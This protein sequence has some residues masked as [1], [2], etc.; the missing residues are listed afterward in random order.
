MIPASA[1]VLLEFIRKTETGH[2]GAQAYET[3]FA[4]KQ[5]ILPK[6]L[7]KMT[8]L[9]VQRGQKDRWGRR[10]K[11]SASGAYQFMY[12]TLGGLIEEL[13]LDVNQKFTPE[14]QDRLGYH[15]LKRR[16]YERWA[17]GTLGDEAFAKYLAMEWAS[18]PVLRKGKGAHRTVNAGQSY[19]AGDGLNKALIS[20]TQVRDVLRRARAANEGA[21]VEEIAPK[22]PERPVQNPVQ[23]ET[24]VPSPKTPDAVKKSLDDA[25]KPLRKSK[26]SWSAIVGIVSSLLS[27]IGGFDK[28][29]QYLLIGIGVLAGVYI[30][31]D[32]KRKAALARQA[33]EVL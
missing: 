3:I 15:L 30:I 8:V 19:Y 17:A 1:H 18:F 31:Y 27:Q 5:S 10:V 4:H 28:E 24:P 11:S 16:N 9:E 6:P 32:R 12:K 14:L 25:D 21:L 23:R 29:I 20:T 26:T 7:T 2:S 22:P 13:G 33:K